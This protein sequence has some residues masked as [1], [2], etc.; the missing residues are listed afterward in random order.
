MLRFCNRDTP[1]AGRCAGG[2]SPT[3][4]SC[5]LFGTRFATRFYCLIMMI[6]PLIFSGNASHTNCKVVPNVPCSYSEFIATE[7]EGTT[8]QLG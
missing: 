3:S 5:R 1:V 2:V 6:R 4:A 7:Y 8:V